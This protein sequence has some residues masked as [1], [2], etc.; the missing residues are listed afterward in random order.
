MNTPN[1]EGASYDVATIAY[2]AAITH[3][4]FEKPKWRL[5]PFAVAY[6]RETGERVYFDYDNRP[7]CRVA[8]GGQVEIIPPDVFVCFS[9]LADLHADLD[10]RFDP[11]GRKIVVDLIERYG[12]ASEL[13]RRWEL[14]QRGALPEPAF[15]GRR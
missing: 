13:S 11:N 5:A 9:L 8:R 6:F 7:I 3:L 4:F 15:G 12:L 14:F 2:E 1:N 10:G